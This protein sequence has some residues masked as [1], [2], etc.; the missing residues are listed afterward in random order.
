MREEWEP[1]SFGDRLDGFLVE[2]CFAGVV[3]LAAYWLVD[4]AVLRRTSA[5]LDG[6]A[7]Q[8]SILGWFLWNVTYQLG[9]TGQSWG[10]KLLG[11]KVV[12]EDGAPIGFLRALGRNMFA[13]I[14]W[15][16]CAPAWLWIAWDP[17]KQALHDK[18]FRTYVIRIGRPTLSLFGES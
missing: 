14:L 1:A 3:V 5:P 11:L 15:L 13:L 4:Y 17:N 6:T 18:V 12:N 10:G 9:K 7:A 16:L 8:V 2:V